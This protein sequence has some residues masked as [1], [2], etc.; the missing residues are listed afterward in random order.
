MR[1]AAQYQTASDSLVGHV[2]TEILVV[3]EFLAS[4]PPPESISLCRKNLGL[5]KP[6]KLAAL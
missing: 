1:N 2:A 3:Q 6:R 5:V 4:Y